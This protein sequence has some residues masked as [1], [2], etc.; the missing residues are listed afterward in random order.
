MSSLDMDAL[1]REVQQNLQTLQG[2]KL[3]NNQQKSEE[4]AMM[5]NRKR[6]ILIGL[7]FFI[8]VISVIFIVSRKD[9]MVKE[10]KGGKTAETITVEVN[11]VDYSE[12]V[13][14]LSAEE[15]AFSTEV[16]QDVGAAVPT[17][18]I[19]L[20]STNPATVKLA[21]GDIQLIELFAFW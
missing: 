8:I 17:A 5:D 12:A 19:E 16:I 13:E 7:A 15:I 10:L 1:I 4:V 20:E 11:E 14:V 2:S 21:S 6:S 18:R 9:R 3:I